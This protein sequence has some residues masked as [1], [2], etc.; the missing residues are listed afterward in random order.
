MSSDRMALPLNMFLFK[1]NIGTDGQYSFA[2]HGLC[3]FHIVTQGWQIYVKPN[4]LHDIDGKQELTDIV[5]IIQSW[6]KSCFFSTES[7]SE[8]FYSKRYFH[9]WINQISQI[10]GDNLH[11]SINHWIKTSL[12]P[13]DTMWLNY[14]KKYMTGNAHFALWKYY[15]LKPLQ[16]TGEC[17]SEKKNECE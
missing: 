1:K 2:V 12:D 13:Y 9:Q 8:Y 17:Q 3:Y 15:L 4:I 6:L 14:L 5:T 7:E 11:S 10:I 16:K